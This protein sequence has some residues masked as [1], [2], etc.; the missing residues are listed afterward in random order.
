MRVVVTGAAGRLARAVVPMLCADPGIGRITGI[1]L[2]APQFRHP[3]FEPIVADIGDRVTLDQ[4]RG[5]GA[6]VH[7]AYVVFRGRRAVEAMARTNVIASRE[8]LSAAAN[9]GVG[10]IVHLSSAA[11]YGKGVDI[12]ED[13]PLAPLPRFQY[14]RQKAAVDAW[15]ARELPSITV[16]RPTIILGPHAHP[17]LLQLAAS[18]CYVRLPEPQPTVQCVHEHDV[19][20]AVRLAIR[21]PAPGAYNLAA[22]SSFSARELVLAHRRHATGIPRWLGRTAISVAWGITG[23]G[24]EPGWLDGIG[25]SL[26]LD[27]RRARTLLQWVPE[28]DDSRKIAGIPD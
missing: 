16:L 14:A 9:A 19:A 25:D 10:S 4:M 24:G 11:V 27:C 2:E 12:A 13:A 21:R 1:D 23:W 26:T 20:A 15:I 8:L 17:L 18:V 5:A 22:A 3:K 6:L 28:Y 7:L